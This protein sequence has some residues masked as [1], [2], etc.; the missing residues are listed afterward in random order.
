MG[1]EQPPKDNINPLF[2]HSDGDFMKNFAIM[3][4]MG[5]FKEPVKQKISRWKKLLCFILGHRWGLS[6]LSYSGPG[7]PRKCKRCDK[8]KWFKK[9]PNYKWVDRLLRPLCFIGFHRWK[10]TYGYSSYCYGHN[11]SSSPMTSEQNYS[12]A[13]CKAKKTVTL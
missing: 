8:Q 7:H 5:P 4:P 6:G 2:D 9:L 11:C 13:R 12:C 1:N 3:I 10:A